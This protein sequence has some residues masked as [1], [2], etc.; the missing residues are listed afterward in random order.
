M[1][2]LT[3]QQKQTQIN[4]TRRR[5]SMSTAA[6]SKTTIKG[7]N[8]MK[9][10]KKLK[11]YRLKAGHTIYTLSD[12]LGVNFSS[13]SYWESGDKFPRRQKLEALE[14]MFG[15]GYRELFKDLTPEEMEEVKQLE[16]DR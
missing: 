15:V 4:H 5:N 11:L 9:T 13:I 1:V 2:R 8:K 16:K 3:H 6:L 12:R 7:G 10:P 14:D